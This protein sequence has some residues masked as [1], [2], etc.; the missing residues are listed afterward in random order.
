VVYTFY[1]SDNGGPKSGLTPT[2]YALLDIAGNVLTGSA[3]AVTEIGA[4]WYKF[5]L[6]FG[7]SPWNSGKLIGV[8][9][10]GTELVGLQR[11][12]PVTVAQQDLA[13]GLL[14]NKRQQTIADGV[15]EVF[16]D[17]GTTVMLRLIPSQAG[18][19]EVITPEGS[20]T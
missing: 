15:I 11:Y 12:L 7:T 10:V 19:K 2:W 3:P 8:I 6:T 18:G 1:V 16:D 14:A 9:D 4:G 17:D 5:E 20:G 13:F